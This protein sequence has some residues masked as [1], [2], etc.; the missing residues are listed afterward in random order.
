MAKVSAVLLRAV[1]SDTDGSRFSANT[2]LEEPGKIGMDG[3]GRSRM[4]V[5]SCP[6]QRR[7]VLALRRAMELR[8]SVRGQ[9]A[10]A[11][12]R[13]ASGVH[14]ANEL[15]NLALRGGVGHLVQHKTDG[16]TFAGCHS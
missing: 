5:P 1:P 16:R 12:L 2:Q 13:E 7:R 3:A 11:R 8:V 9:G 14:L 6:L 4:A 10:E 15:P